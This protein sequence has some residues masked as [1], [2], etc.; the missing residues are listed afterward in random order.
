MALCEYC[1]VFHKLICFGHLSLVIA[2]INIYLF[3]I[4]KYT[5]NWENLGPFRVS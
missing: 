5:Q 1:L 4:I 3:G 2:S